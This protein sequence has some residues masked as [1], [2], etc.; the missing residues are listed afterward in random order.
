MI[1][2]TGAELCQAQ[3]K[4]GVAKPAL[5]SKKFRFFSFIKFIG[6]L[7]IENKMS[8]S[9]SFKKLMSSSICQTIDVVVHQPK[10]LGPL[11][12]SKN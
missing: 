2:Q 10:H 1:R 6:H 7:P 11:P 5:P 9:F 8:L 4:L 3:D 12:F